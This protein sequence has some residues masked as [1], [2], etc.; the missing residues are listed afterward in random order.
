MT[1]V[2]DDLGDEAATDVPMRRIKFTVNGAKK[3]DR[4]SVV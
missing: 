2:Y 3:I 4:K 1:I